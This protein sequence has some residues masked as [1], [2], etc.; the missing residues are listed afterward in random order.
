MIV[1]GGLPPRSAGGRFHATQG[2]ASALCDV[3]NLARSKMGVARTGLQVPLGAYL[4][5]ITV[6]RRC[7]SAL[8]KT[9]KAWC[10]SIG[11]GVGSKRSIIQPG[12]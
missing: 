6:Q 2:A 12:E 8:S 4:N 11:I 1:I 3:N 7:C 10:R 9:E 5:S